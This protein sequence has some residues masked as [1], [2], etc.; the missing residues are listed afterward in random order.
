MNIKLHHSKSILT[1]RFFKII[2]AF[3][4]FFISACNS[5]QDNDKDRFNKELT[6]A[7]NEVNKSCPIM[8][9]GE[10]RL[11]NAMALPGNTFAYYYTLVNVEVGMLDTTQVKEILAPSI[12]A[13][14]K[15]SPDMESMR[16]TGCNFKYT[17][18]DKGGNYLFA[19]NVTPADYQPQ[20][21]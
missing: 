1:N 3:L 20:K 8:V 11:D 13:M 7:A 17:Y 15:T 12:K 14:I 9:D 10:T 5:E 19:I 16:K 6:A 18:R 2:L 4:P 21:P